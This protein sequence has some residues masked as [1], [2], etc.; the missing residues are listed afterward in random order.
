MQYFS[1]AAVRPTLLGSAA[2]SATALQTEQKAR[3]ARRNFFVGAGLMPLE[4]GC[5]ARSEHER[6]T[7][8]DQQP[9]PRVRRIAAPCRRVRADG[10]ARTRHARAFAARLELHW[11]TS[12]RQDA[13]DFLPAAGRLKPSRRRTR[14]STSA[15]RI[16]PEPAGGWGYRRRRLWS[17]RKSPGR[18]CAP[19]PRC[20][21]QRRR[22]PDRDVPA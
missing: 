1:P 14:V 21:Q 18:L 6:D 13:R 22:A 15:W 2:E 17:A 9:R 3:A 7:A 11:V 5:H 20:Q 19:D 4:G 12:A 10:C 16:R 8:R